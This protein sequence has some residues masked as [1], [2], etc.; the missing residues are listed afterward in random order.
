MEMD[1]KLKEVMES[2]K[3]MERKMEEAMGQI[4]ILDLDF[5]VES[6]ARKLLVEEAVKIIKEKVSLHDREECDRILKRTRVYTLGKSLSQKQTQT[7]KIYTVPVLLA[8]QCKSEKDRLEEILKKGRMH[9]SFQWPKESLEFVNGVREEVE[10]MGY[11]RRVYFTRLRPIYVD[12]RVMIR[13][14]CRNKEGG[15]F[16]Q[17]ARWRLPPLDRTKWEC[18]NGILEPEKS[19]GQG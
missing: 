6:K 14:E 3:E 2:E 17:V 4:K 11:G 8:C 16:E 15:K 5:G 19:L 10:R 12:G 7:G 18:L 13:A 1:K 9:V